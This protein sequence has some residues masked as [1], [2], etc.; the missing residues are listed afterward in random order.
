[1]T[2]NNKKEILNVRTTLR[3]F[4]TCLN[5]SIGC[6]FYVLKQENN[7]FV[8]AAKKIAWNKKMNS[9]GLAVCP[10]FLICQKKFA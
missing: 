7:Y 10:Q 8:Q 9:V 3:H 2:L 4:L 5:A 1:M 6:Q